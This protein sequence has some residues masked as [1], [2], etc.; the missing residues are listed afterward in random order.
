M[1]ANDVFIIDLTRSSEELHAD[2]DQNRRRQLRGWEDLRQT[3][4]TEREPLAAFFLAHCREF[5]QRANAGPAYA[6]TDETL[7]T[8][9]EL[10][11]VLLAG[12]GRGGRIEAVSV[13]AYTAYAADYLFNISL[14]T[15]R[16]HAVP[17]I[18]YAVHE[19]KARGIPALNLGG[20]ARRDDGIGRFK[21]RF[22]ARRMPLGALKQVYDDAAYTR[23][24][25]GRG[26][27][28]LDRTGYF[29]AYWAPG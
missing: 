26:R 14:P 22:G 10:D 12:R 15:G 11:D 4:I 3:I 7:A 28:P 25:Q 21:E 13:F 16:D 2:L 27:D 6:F 9:A 5:L 20:G 19:L 8:L 23:I 29:P 1:R 18:W 24:C 17:L